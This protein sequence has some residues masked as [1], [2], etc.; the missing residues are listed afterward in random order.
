MEQ[1]DKTIDRARQ[2]LADLKAAKIPQSRIAKEAGIN[3]VTLWQIS[4]GG[5][6]SVSE[7]VF[8]A[9]WD[10]WSEHAPPKGEPTNGQQEPASGPQE[11]SM[12]VK[13]AKAKQSK[14]KGP[15]KQK[16]TV[17][18]VSKTT[19]KAATKPAK[20]HPLDIEGMISRDYVPVDL[21]AL[22]ALIDGMI[23]RFQA[24]VIELETVKKKLVE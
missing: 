13:P 3:G 6:S 15:R 4:K 8:D 2:M 16:R 11:A 23:E 24:Q 21:R 18:K 10:Y 14:A 17:Q 12:A 1:V 20:Q 5:Q 9:I 19:V 7:R 22:V